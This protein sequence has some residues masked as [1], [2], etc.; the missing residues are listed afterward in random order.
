MTKNQI[1]EQLYISKEFCDCISKMEPVQLQ[2]D[3]KSEVTLILLEKPDDLIV[4]LHTS[5]KL[6]FF[7][8]RVILNLIQSN[9]SPFFK[10]LRTSYIELDPDKDEADNTDISDRVEFELQEQIV[11]NELELYGDNDVLTFYERELVKLYL[12]FGSYRAIEDDTRIPWESCYK[13]IRGA[14][15]KL[16]YYAES[17][18]KEC[19]PCTFLIKK[20]K[21]DTV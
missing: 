18:Q 14:L 20:V 21:Y 6:K 5:G 7:A 3:L 8:V 11:L 16:K 9:T 4:E 12:K 1:I 10:K 13:T 19:V 17:K 2:D 15:K